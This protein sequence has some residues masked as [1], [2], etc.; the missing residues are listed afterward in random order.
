MPFASK[1]L[2]HLCIP[3]NIEICCS[4]AEP[5][6]HQQNKEYKNIVIRRLFGL[7]G[8]SKQGCV[9]EVRELGG[10]GGY[11]GSIPFE[12]SLDGHRGVRRGNTSRQAVPHSCHSSGETVLKLLMWKSRVCCFN[13]MPPGKNMSV[14]VNF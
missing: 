11:G 2:V 3:D 10:G 9:A 7:S 12:S 5:L 6:W 1:I 13:G 14:C 4:V 8:R